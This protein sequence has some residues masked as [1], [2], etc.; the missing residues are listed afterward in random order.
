MP[1]SLYEGGK[2]R[3]HFTL[4]TSAFNHLSSI[5]KDAELSRSETLERL[6][7]C[8]PI[9]EGGSLIA[10]HTWPFAWDYSSESSSESSPEL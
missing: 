5:A 10:D 2:Q 6:I 1:K 4:T 7:R 3:R 9:T 8:T